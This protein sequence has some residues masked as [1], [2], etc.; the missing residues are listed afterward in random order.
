MENRTSL[1]LNNF[2]S[3]NAGKLHGIA[4]VTFSEPWPIT[5]HEVKLFSGTRG[6]FVALGDSGKPHYT[7]LAEFAN[8]GDGDKFAAELVA[9]IR[10][11]FPGALR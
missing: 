8:R 5:L 10:E 1:I 11:R 3:V 7:K 4:D 6:Y 9:L 2:R